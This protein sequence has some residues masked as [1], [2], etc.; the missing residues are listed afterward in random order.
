MDIASADLDPLDLERLVNSVVVPRPIAW[1]TTLDESGRGNLAPFSY[2]NVVSS[3]HPPIVMVSFSPKGKKDTL[4]NLVARG[5]FVV[6]LVSDELRAAMVASSAPLAAGDDEARRVGL[7][8][9]A[10]ASV[11]VPRLA[12]AR[13]ALECRTHATQPVG[14]FTMVFGAVAHFHVDDAVIRDGRVDPALLAPV[15]RL[16]GSLYATVS[17]PYRLERPEAAPDQAG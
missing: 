17:E 12:A 9:A 5:E 3:G 2:F 8:T 6:N 14:E 15:G 16:G 4:A 1:I 10:S 7:D 11:S 13:A